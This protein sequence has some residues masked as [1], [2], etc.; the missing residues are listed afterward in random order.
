MRYSEAFISFPDL[1][2]C[3]ASRGSGSMPFSST[4]VA[5]RSL[6]AAPMANARAGPALATGV[7]TSAHPDAAAEAEDTN[8][9][10]R[11]FFMSF[12]TGFEVFDNSTAV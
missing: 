7:V 6:T 5:T 9:Y 3:K 11:W 4:F 2:W 1:P 12:H 10:G 8:T